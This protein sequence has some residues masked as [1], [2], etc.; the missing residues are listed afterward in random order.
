M[1]CIRSISALARLI[2]MLKVRLFEDGTFP[3]TIFGIY[4]R[5]SIVLNIKYFFTN[6][7][8]MEYEY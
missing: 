3:A 6:L 1:Y 7:K 5:H 8:I 2:E 4:L